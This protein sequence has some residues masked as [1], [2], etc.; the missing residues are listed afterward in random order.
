MVSRFRSLRWLL[1]ALVPLSRVVAQAP[2]VTLDH[3]SK[4]HVVFA[5]EWVRVLD[6]VVPSGDSTLY[7]VHSNDYVF[8][9][10]GDVALKA[11]ALGAAQTDLP[12]ANGEVRITMAPIT[13][14]VLNPSRSPFHNLTIELLKPSGMALTPRAEGVTVLDNDRVRVGRIVL[15][16]GESTTRHEHRGPGLDVGVSAGTV[17]VVDASGATT[18][19]TY[20]PASYRWSAAGRTHTLT[21]VG[22][23][24]VEIVE[25]E[26]K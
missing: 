11:Q 2:A 4:H 13:H 3:E 12:L 19:V 15:E 6:V 1:G 5:N 21:N 18:R 22:R 16:P 26:W 20:A 24:R 7:H 8:V 10:F 25:I 14:R 17:S 23:S 9:T